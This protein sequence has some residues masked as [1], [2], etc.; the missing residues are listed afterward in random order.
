VADHPVPIGTDDEPGAR[1]GSVHAESA[2]PLKRSRPWTS[3]IVAAQKAL[4][5]FRS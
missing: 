2:F 1:P 5:L 4:S 3:L